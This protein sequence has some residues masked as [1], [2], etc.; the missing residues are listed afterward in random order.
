MSCPALTL[1]LLCPF[2][3]WSLED[4]LLLVWG[5]FYALLRESP[6]AS[7]ECVIHRTP[8]SPFCEFCSHANCHVERLRL[9]NS[10]GQRVYNGRRTWP[11]QVRSAFCFVTNLIQLL[12]PDDRTR[13]RL[14]FPACVP[15]QA[16]RH[17]LEGEVNEE[18]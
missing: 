8:I 2:S 15:F 14:I 13:A 16:E 10:D 1:G 4:R 3:V 5:I 11:Y 7:L 18:K 12:V 9:A 17:G 6:R